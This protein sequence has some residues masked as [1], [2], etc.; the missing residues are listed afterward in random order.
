LDQLRNRTGAATTIGGLDAG[1]LLAPDT[2]RRI[3]CDAGVIPIVLGAEGEV[4]DWGRERRLFTPAQ[5][6]GLWLRDG[7]CTFPGCSAPPQWCDVHHLVHWADHGPTDLGNAALLC[8]RHHTIVHSRRLAGHVADGHL[9]DDRPG[10]LVRWD[11]TRGSY[12]DLLRD[13]G[14]PHLRA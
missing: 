12:D 9:A 1:T 13:R 7:G 2:V 6:K 14:V 8:E 11:L 5:T 4:L 3:A 10:G